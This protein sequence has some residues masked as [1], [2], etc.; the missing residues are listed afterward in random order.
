MFVEI[1]CFQSEINIGIKVIQKRNMTPCLFARHLSWHGS[2]IFKQ[3][4]MIVRLLVDLWVCIK[5]SFRDLWTCRLDFSL[6]SAHIM[7]NMS[8]VI[9]LKPMLV[10][11]KRKSIKV[12]LFV[13][14]ILS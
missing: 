12:G 1:G 14:M 7:H 4:M 11:K 3:P 2:T 5:I 13:A 9:Y 8:K 10:L 6:P